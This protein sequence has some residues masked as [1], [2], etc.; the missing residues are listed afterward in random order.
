[1][2]QRT[3]GEERVHLKDME[4]QCGAQPRRTVQG[5]EEDH[6]TGSEIGKASLHSLGLE[7]GGEGRCR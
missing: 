6:V 5:W 4:N 1:M 3:V 2:V 7:T